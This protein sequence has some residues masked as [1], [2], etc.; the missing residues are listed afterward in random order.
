MSWFTNAMSSSIGKKVLMA[1]T[2]LF[3]VTFLIVHL[4]GNLQLLLNDGG[5]AF[6]IYAKFM[7]TNPVIKATSYLL[8]AT[9]IVHI[10]WALIITVGNKKARPTGYAVQPGNVSST[11]SSKNMGLLGTI[12]LVFLVIHLKQFWYEMHWGG[13]PTANYDG[14][15][16][17]D[18]YA[19]VNVAFHELWYVVL[20]TISMMALMFH[21]N[22]GFKSAFQSLGAN[23][24]KYNPLIK[25][26]GFIIAI[27]IPALFAAIPIIMYM[28]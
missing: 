8:Y 10:V 26:V 28:K 23:H 6:N 14:M 13:I 18:L 12:I 15:E 20:Y 27:V 1:L 7:T 5:K 2:G 16:Y 22:H 24:P 11:W 17:N 25:G 9:F 19:V 21:L 3:L 4:S